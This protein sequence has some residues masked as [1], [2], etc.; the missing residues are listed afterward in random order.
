MLVT[1]VIIILTAEMLKYE[2]VNAVPYSI[3]ALGW[4]WSG[5]LGS[6]PALDTSNKPGSMLTL[7]STS[8][9]VTFSAVSIT[10]FGQY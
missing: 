1:R 8:R 7:L 10:A 2:V 3:W 6:R 9:A 4:H 5:C